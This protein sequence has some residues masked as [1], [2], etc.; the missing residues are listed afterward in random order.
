MAHTYL[1]GSY[2]EIYPH[3]EQ[4]RDG[5]QAA[6]PPVLLALRD[7]QPRRAGNSR[8]D[9]RR[10]RAGLLAAARLRRGVRQSQ[11]DRRL[12]RR[13]RRSGDRPLRHKL[14]L[15]QIPQSR[16]GRRG[17]ADP[18]PQR[19]QDRQSHSAG[20]HPAGG[21]DALFRATATSPTSSK[22]TIPSTMHQQMAATLDT[23][24]DRD[25]AHPGPRAR[26]AA[27]RAPALA[28]ADP[29]HAKG[30][31]RPQGRRRQ[32]GRRHLALAPGAVRASCAKSPS[33]SRSS[34]TG[35]GAT[36]RKSSSTPTASSSRSWP[37]LAPKGRR[38]M[39][40]NPHANG[41]L[42]LEPLRL[43]DFRDYAVEV[44][45][46]ARPRRGDAR[47]RRIPARRHAAQPREPEFPALRPRRNR[48]EP[49]RRRA[50]GHRQDLGSR[51][52]AGRREPRH[53]RPRDG[54]P[55][56]APVPRLARGLPAHRPARLL[57]VLRG[58]HP[59]RRLDVQPARQVAQEL[60]RPSRGESR[61]PRSTTCSPPTS[62][63]RTTTASR[64]RIPASSITSP[65]RRPTSSA[66]YLPP[67]A[68]T[69]ALRGGPLPPQPQLHQP[70]R[71][72]KAAGADSGSTWTPPCAI[73][74][75]VSASGSGRATT[76]AS[77]KWSWPAPATCRRWR[78]SPRSSL[79]REELP[80][81]RVRVVN[82]VDLMTLQP[83]SEHP[84]GLADD[85]FDAL[86]T[87]DK[88]MIFA[89]H[90]YPRLSTA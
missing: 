84:H 44:T 53:G 86:F 62:G 50:R 57:L 38:R 66:I 85:E 16:D 21:T 2:T 49:P 87:S 32:A 11:P 89:F 31:D 79:L 70:H 33:T 88:P 81:L 9:P 18:P 60:S 36:G 28:H 42:L 80:D 14:A 82:V 40:M 47:A 52:A 71:R 24:L 76:R 13:R 48:L 58:L 15:E 39:G 29:A 5:M 3:I 17:A 78:P 45:N 68:N 35:C 69:P 90:G 63:G 4:N 65:T 6:L 12:R 1:E 43:P 30:L 46:P 22:A 75:P 34:K 10:R 59:H 61:S 72:R 26:R 67:D 51:D 74:Q 7:P 64:T 27:D 55:Q 23:I 56:R 37:A 41:G 20:P 73:A 8:L 83:R 77:P 25:P 19:L 54:G